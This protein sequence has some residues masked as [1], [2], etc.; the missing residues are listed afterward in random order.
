MGPDAA[1]AFHDRLH[2]V[3]ARMAEFGVDA[4]LLSVGADLPW[5]CGYEAMPLERL[6]MLVVPAK[7]DPTL[8][9]P[10]LEA[11]R[12]ADRPDLFRMIPWDETDNPIKIVGSLIGS[13]I[14]LGV[15]DH[16]WS[17][18]LL[19]LQEELP[20]R[21]WHPASI[22]TAPL[23]AA[24]DA[25]ELDCL[26][27]ASAAADR[28]ANAI[29]AGEIRFIGRSEAEVAHDIG[30]RLVAEGHERVAF[31]IVASGP[32]S[33][34]PHHEPGERIIGPGEAVV[35]DFGGVLDGY[36]SDITRTVVTG[37]PSPELSEMYAVIAEAQTAGISTALVGTACSD[38]DG[39]ARDVI[40]DAGFGEFF[41]HRTGHGIGR[42][43][44]EE[45]YLVEGNKTLLEVGN[46]FS[47]EPGI[48]LPGRFGAR[49]EDIIVATE[50]GPRSLNTANHE[51]VTV[52]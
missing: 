27:R 44:H 13:R 7:E 10:R 21:R 40:A 42:D 50:D 36:C 6:T 31:V 38:V 25:A 3:R 23:R 5:M 17:R 47:V 35:C 12:V 45:P 52:G 26:A 16:T 48:Y 49:L 9:V 51:L 28:V 22:I 15:G 11:P 8:V 20:A 18:F 43:V 30:R 1:A 41:P 32:N 33:A 34:S 4:L 37:E 2:R 19:A 14:T 29:H 39:A 24:K 46:A